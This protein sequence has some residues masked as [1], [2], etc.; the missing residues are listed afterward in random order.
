MYLENSAPY[1]RAD[2]FV[3]NWGNVIYAIDGGEAIFGVPLTDNGNHFQ[4]NEPRVDE[5]DDIIREPDDTYCRFNYRHNNFYRWPLDRF[6][7]NSDQQYPAV[8]QVR[9]N[10]WGDGS[11]PPQI[12]E[13][14]PDYTN[15][16]AYDWTGY[17]D[18][19][20]NIGLVNNSGKRFKFGTDD[21]LLEEAIQLELEGQYSQAVSTYQEFIATTDDVIDKIFAMRRLLRATIVGELNLP[22]LNGYYQTI[23]AQSSNSLVVNAAAD[24]QIQV[25][26]AMGDYEDAILDYEEILSGNSAFTDSALSVI[27][28]GRAYVL[29]A[30]NSGNPPPFNPQMPWLEPDSV[31]HR[32][33]QYYKR[34]K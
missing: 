8:T 17:N 1:F 14:N 21:D 13:F 11:N 31:E 3:H 22:S 28:A 33:P 25:K 7:D 32:F 30:A 4:W 12:T 23:I 5:F 34:Q 6:I 26:I 2:S 19:D 9:E 29:R 10:Y 24:M 16:N 27:G 15:P 18:E 20:Y